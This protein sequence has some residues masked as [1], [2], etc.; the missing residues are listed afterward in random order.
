M[1]E[2]MIVPG[3]TLSAAALAIE[4][5]LPAYYDEVRERRAMSEMLLQQ[6]T[7]L[8]QTGYLLERKVRQLSDTEAHW[9]CQ[10]VERL[11]QDEPIQ[12]ILGKAPFG[13]FELA[14]GKGVLIPR[15]ETAELCELI[16]SRHTDAETSLRLL[17][18]GCGTACI[19]IYIGRRCPAWQLYAMDLSEQALR[20]AEQN[21]QKTDVAVELLRGDL[22]AWS[23]GEGLPETVPPIDI[24]VSNPPY[25]PERDQATMRPNVL[26]GEPHEALF[27]PDDDPLRYYEALVALVPHFRSPHAP[28]ALYCETHHQLAHEVAQL[29]RHAGG[30]AT[31]LLTDMSGR[32]RFVRTIFE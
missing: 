18:V 32:P 4:Q 27:V 21:V 19:P 2:P 8:S 17:D 10:A 12:Y 20:Y 9:L 24:L 1:S 14:V 25:I 23:R 30:Q 5:L 29:C 16:V 22:F 26:E 28:L 31:E 3:M 7:Q 13:S 11:A 15:P 6:V